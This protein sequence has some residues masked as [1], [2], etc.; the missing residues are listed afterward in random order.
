MKTIDESRC[1]Y[2]LSEIMLELLNKAI[3]LHPDA[4]A[5]ALSYRDP[6]HSVESGGYHPVEIRINHRGEI[7]YITDFTYYGAG[8]YAEL[9]KEID[10]DFSNDT[11]EHM[12][13]LYP[14]EEGRELFDVWQQ[15]FTSYVAAGVF[16]CT[17]SP[18]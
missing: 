1:P 7:Q 15:N 12:S 3:A 16:E 5:I 13:H 8:P 18:E 4:S 14:L 9:G 17:V 10:F 6:S 2:T 11:F